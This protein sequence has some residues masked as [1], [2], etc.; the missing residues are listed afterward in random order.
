MKAAIAISAV[1][2]G[3]VS[4]ALPSISS[5]KEETEPAPESRE[6]VVAEVEQAEVEVE[7][8]RKAEEAQRVEEAR[9]AE[10]ARIAE[11]A[12]V[13]EEAQ[14]AEEAR[15]AEEARIAE[16]AREAEEAEA[17][18]LKEEALTRRI[19]RK[20]A[21][22]YEK[23][24]KAD[25]DFKALLTTY[26]AANRRLMSQIGH[27]SADVVKAAGIDAF[28]D[29]STLRKT[30]SACNEAISF[31]EKQV[32]STKSQRK[33]L[34]KLIAMRDAPELRKMLAAVAELNK[35]WIARRDMFTRVKE[36]VLKPAPQTE[37]E[38]VLGGSLERMLGIG[39]GR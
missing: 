14:Q 8:A 26:N 24:S 29:S 30:R 2:L 3:I 36:Q 13:A 25:E 17:A 39:G 38:R 9:L 6:A 5:S 19:D 22:V 33:D 35:T 1:L 4:I 27:V 37:A 15:L 18:R 23:A 10:E 32:R 28:A 20:C 16:E 34:E 12:R 31:C 11:E 7:A 21:S